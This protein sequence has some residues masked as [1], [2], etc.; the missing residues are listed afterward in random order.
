METKNTPVLSATANSEPAVGELSR[1]QLLTAGPALA[2]APSLSAMLLSSEAA[3]GV[4]PTDGKIPGYWSPTDP[5]RPPID[6][7][8][9]QDLWRRA[10][11]VMPSYAMFLTRSAR[12]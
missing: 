2:L 1:R 9:G 8:K 6:G 5:N 12:Y 11:K 7:P 4:A 3:G 10:D